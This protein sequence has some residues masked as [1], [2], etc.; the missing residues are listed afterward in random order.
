MRNDTEVSAIDNGKSTPSSSRRI[1]SVLARVLWGGHWLLRIWLAG[2]LLV[3]GW[4][5]VFLMQM[6]YADYSDALIQY[7]EMS[8]MGLLWRFMGFS[9][10]VQFLAGAAEVTAAILLLFRRTVWL[11]A[12]LA[13]VD[14]SV[15]FLLNLTFYVPVKQLAGMMALAGLI[16]LI[17]N[18]V[19]LG[20][21][22]IGLPTGAPIQGRI[23]DNRIFVAITRWASPLLAVVLIVG[24]GVAFGLRTNW[25][26]L[27][28]APV[29]A[30]VYRADDGGQR[31]VDGA[32]ITQMA[33]GQ[34]AVGGKARVAIRFADGSFQDGS[35]QVKDDGS[36][37][38]SLYPKL[39]GDQGLVRDVSTRMGLRYDLGDQGR[40]RLTGDG[41]DL[42][43]VP[44]PERRY[45]YDRDFSWAPREAIHR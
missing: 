35:Y 9:P 12:T 30:G 11:G 28:P 10:V 32:E 41:L 13:V 27:D 44:D 17:P 43:L 37:A 4:S 14:M 22:L 7:G 34:I 24:S 1:R 19:R 38:L 45:L 23:S 26:Q 21:F 31:T 20:R 16:L 36:L 8:P 39:A 2:Y 42:T 5:K 40:L 3:Y 33:F 18:L 6:G 25:G 29:V 15:V